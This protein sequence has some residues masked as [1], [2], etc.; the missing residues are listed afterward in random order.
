MYKGKVEVAVQ[1]GVPME[2]LWGRDIIIDLLF[3]GGEGESRTRLL[4][5]EV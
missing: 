4:K 5:L 2:V 1:D 3:V